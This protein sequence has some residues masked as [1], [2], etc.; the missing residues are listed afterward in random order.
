MDDSVHYY[1]LTWL[2]SKV[3]DGLPTGKQNLFADLA[4]CASL[5]SLICH[6]FL[7]MAHAFHIPVIR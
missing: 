6:V 1:I 7:G 5:A 2:L 3:C 4:L